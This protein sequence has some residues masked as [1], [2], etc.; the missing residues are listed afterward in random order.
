MRLTVWRYQ[1][2]ACGA[3]YELANA[4]LSFAYGVFLAHSVSGSVAIFDASD[5]T[6]DE[7]QHLVEQDNHVHS[8][9]SGERVELLHE[10]LPVAMDP[11]SNGNP[12]VIAGSPGCPACGSRSVADF[13]ETSDSAGEVD[14][15][16]TH[17][18]WQSLPAPERATKVQDRLHTL[19]DGG[20]PL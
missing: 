6:F 19:L 12:F 1:C 15:R 4:D 8:L 18:T 20:L 3:S 13:R 10:V 11:D 7:V 5:P 17:Y 2:G 9:T 16:V 14:Q